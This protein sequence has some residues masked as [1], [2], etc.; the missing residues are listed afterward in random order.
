MFILCFIVFILL[1]VL[2]INAMFILTP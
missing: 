2:F 1:S